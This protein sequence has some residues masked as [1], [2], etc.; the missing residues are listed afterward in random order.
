MKYHVNTVNNF[1]KK[2]GNEYLTI[3]QINPDD[4]TAEWAARDLSL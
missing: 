2:H 3:K 4:G 1:I